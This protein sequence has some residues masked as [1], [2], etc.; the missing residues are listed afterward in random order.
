MLNK[1]EELHRFDH[2]PHVQFNFYI[3]GD[4]FL[5]LE[6]EY[7]ESPHFA[8]F[9]LDPETDGVLLKRIM[10]LDPGV[11]GNTC[12][13]YYERPLRRAPESVEEALEEYERMAEL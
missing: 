13:F 2:L 3:E 1:W 4:G 12:Y 6:G 5:S 7:Y 8:A 11:I 10:G 9:I